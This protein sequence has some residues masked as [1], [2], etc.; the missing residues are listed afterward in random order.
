MYT[1]LAVRRTV[2]SHCIP[3]LTS[4]KAAEGSGV[5]EREPTP[6]LACPSKVSNRQAGSVSQRVLGNLSVMGT[7]AGKSP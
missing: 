4:Q 5:G 2:K 6:V 3:C 1:K 7:E